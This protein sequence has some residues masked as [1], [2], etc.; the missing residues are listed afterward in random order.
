VGR[1]RSRITKLEGQIEEPSILDVSMQ[2][3]GLPAY[4]WHWRRA[5]ARASQAERDEIEKLFEEG[6]E[7][8]FLE[9]WEEVLRRQ[10][11]TLADDVL[12]RRDGLWRELERAEEEWREQGRHR[13]TSYSDPAFWNVATAETNRRTAV[14]RGAPLV[15]DPEE[16]ERLFD[17]IANAP[18]IAEV[19][20]HIDWQG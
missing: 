6:D 13:S 15:T 4:E 8:G 14:I 3:S 9:R 19:L 2:E 16:V 20:K 12:V 10:A 18:S 17:L 1:L 5:W 11:P 7:A